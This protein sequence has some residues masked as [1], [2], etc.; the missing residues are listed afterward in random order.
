M[1]RIL[2]PL[3]VLA[4]FVALAAD[5]VPGG[6]VIKVLPF[7]LDLQGREAKS[8][9]LFD[10][11]AYQAYLRIHTNEITAIRFD[12]QWKATK[13]T[14]EDLRIRLEIRGVGDRGMPTTKTFETNAPAGVFHGWTMFALGGD[15]RKKF[16]GV[17]AWRATLWN[18]DQLFGE[19]QSFLW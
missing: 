19:Q 11:D 2:I 16:G 13:T 9:S 17:V 3:L 14:N 4:S 5:V 6:R 18:G 7:L 10:R 15:E 1:R 8:P 12:I